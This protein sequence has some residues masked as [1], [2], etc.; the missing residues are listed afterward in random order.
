MRTL[1]DMWWDEVTYELRD[2]HWLVLVIIIVPPVLMAALC[3]I[4]RA[5]VFLYASLEIYGI[6]ALLVFITISIVAAYRTYKIR[7]LKNEYVIYKIKDKLHGF[8]FK[9]WL[10][11][12]NSLSEEEKRRRLKQQ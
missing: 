9:I 1:L 11:E 10:V 12:W 8:R 4:N 3:D 7:H 5:L 6:I 2:F